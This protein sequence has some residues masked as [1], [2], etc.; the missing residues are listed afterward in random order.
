MARSIF[1]RKMHK[2]TIHGLTPRIGAILAAL[3]LLLA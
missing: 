2:F 1:V 3:V